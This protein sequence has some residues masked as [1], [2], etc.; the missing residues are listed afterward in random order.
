MIKWAFMLL[1]IIL[2]VI[3]EEYRI[4]LTSEMLKAAKKCAWKQ[5]IKVAKKKKKA[6]TNSRISVFTFSK[7][8]KPTNDAYFE[9]HES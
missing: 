7:Y 3:R 4:F 1:L 5:H 9:K 8:S 6:R 2:V